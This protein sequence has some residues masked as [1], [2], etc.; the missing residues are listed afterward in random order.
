VG[1]ARREPA[2]VRWPVVD[3]SHGWGLKSR[4]PPVARPRHAGRATSP[5]RAPRAARRHV[6]PLM[7]DGRVARRTAV[8]G[9]GDAGGCGRWQKCGPAR[10]AAGR[11]VMAN[12][13]G[14][15][16]DRSLVNGGGG[17]RRPHFG[18]ILEPSVNSSLMCAKIL[19]DR[20]FCKFLPATASTSSREGGEAGFGGGG[21]R[22][23]SV[24]GRA[25]RLSP[26]IVEQPLMLGGGGCAAGCRHRLAPAAALAAGWVRLHVCVPRPPW[27]RRRQLRM[28]P[29]H[30][31]ASSCQPEGSRQSSRGRS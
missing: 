11:A 5:S 10:G 31:S 17:R 29:V 9:G 1:R 19:C 8:L 18:R 4:P 28:Y 2:P 15:N 16:V 30:R 26:F 20:H 25:G 3:S 23:Y 24:R 27:Q 6:A 12:A 13:A 21:E 7:I 22:H 14:R